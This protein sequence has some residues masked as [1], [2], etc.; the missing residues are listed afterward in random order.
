MMNREN[1]SLIVKIVKVTNDNNNNF[2]II[3][4]RIIKFKFILISYH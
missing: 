2:T 1:E 4:L 3:M